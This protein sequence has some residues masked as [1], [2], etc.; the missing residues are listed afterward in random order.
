MYRRI[1]VHVEKK[2]DSLY[3]GRKTFNQFAKKQETIEKILNLMFQYFNKDQPESF[4]SFTNTI[5][6]EEYKKIA[7]IQR[8]IA[9]LPKITP[10]IPCSKIPSLPAIINITNK[11]HDEPSTAFATA[12][13]LSNE[14]N[15][16]LSNEQILYDGFSWEKW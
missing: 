15:N 13:N 3:I 5:L 8:Q 1:W 16:L 6:T 4:P 12:D 11:E 7:Q 10:L 14:V 9:R 2:C